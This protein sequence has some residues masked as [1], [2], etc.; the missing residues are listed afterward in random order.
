[1]GHRGSCSRSMVQTSSQVPSGPFVLQTF[2]GG[3]GGAAGGGDWS[4]GQLQPE[5]SQPTL[6][7][8]QTGLLYCKPLPAGPAGP[9]AAARATT[10]CILHRSRRRSAGSGCMVGAP[11]TVRSWAPGSDMVERLVAVAVATAAATETAAAAAKGS[12]AAATVTAAKGLVAAATV[13]AAKGW[14]AAAKGAVAAA[15]VTAA[16][17]SVGAATAA[18]AKG[19]AA[20]ETATAAAAT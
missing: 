13:M 6:V 18:A 17:G 12:V 4:P 15:T 7:R 16:K 3:A 19:W 10:E 11:S 9:V 2:A 1:M 20:A 8:F 5:Q 14:A